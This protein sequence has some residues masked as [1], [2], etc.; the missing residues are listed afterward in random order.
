MTSCCSSVSRWYVLVTNLLF[1]CLGLAFL[2]FGL[3]GYKEHFKGSTL[4][5]DSYFYLVAILGGIIIVSAILGI[6]QAFVRSKALLLIY[7][8]VVLVALVY[9]I[10]IGIKV[11]KKAADPVGYLAPLWTS[12]PESYRLHVQDEFNCCGFN[13][14]MDHPAITSE[15]NPQAGKVLHLAPCYNSLV[16]YIKSYFSKLYLVL[17]AALAIELL[18]LSNAITILCTQRSLGDAYDRHQRRRSGIK[19]DE[20]SVVDSPTTIVGSHNHLTEEE[21]KQYIYSSKPHE[22]YANYN[23]NSNSNSNSNLNDSHHY[24]LYGDPDRSDSHQRLNAH[25]ERVNHYY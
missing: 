21:H 13:N 23:S 24:N 6:T 25:D 9:Q 1:I 19:L 12:S 15:C 14:N 2:V 18:A 8:L 4:F 20:I 10:V 5:P 22:P 7:I 11:Y 17:F 16:D 3:L